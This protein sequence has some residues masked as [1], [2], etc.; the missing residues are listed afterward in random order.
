[1]IGGVDPMLMQKLAQMRAGQMNGQMPQ[2]GNNIPSASTVSNPQMG[3]V[4]PPI[5]QQPMA[6]QGIGQ[7]NPQVIQALIARRNMMQMQQP[8][9]M[10]P[11][12]MGQ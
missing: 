7:L 9:G 3:M 4:Q 6:Q 2:M 11:N 12:P 5:S 10:Q 8:S 1:M